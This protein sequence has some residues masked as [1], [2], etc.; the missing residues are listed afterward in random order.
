MPEKIKRKEPTTTIN[1]EKVYRPTNGKPSKAQMELINRYKEDYKIRG[2][3]D[4]TL[5]GI[6]SDC[7]YEIKECI[8]NLIR[9]KD[10][11]V[12]KVLPK[13]LD[14]KI[15]DYGM[16]AQEYFGSEVRS[17]KGSPVYIIPSS[18]CQCKKCD[19]FLPKDKFFTVKT[20]SCREASFLCKDCA[21][22]LFVEY[23]KQY[24]L[25]EALILISQKLDLIVINSVLNKY[26]DYYGTPKGKTDFTKRAFLGNYIGDI[27]I[28]LYTS[29]M[30]S[31]DCCF[32]KSNLH[33][34]PFRDIYPS[35]NQEQI[36]DDVVM[37]QEDEE[38]NPTTYKSV[39]VLK[40]KWGTFDKDDLYWLEDKYNEWYDKCEIEGLSREKLV[41][42]LCYEELDVVRTRERGGN[43]KD[44]VRSFQSLMKDADL[45]PKKKTTANI[46]SGENRF[47][48]LG[49]FIK[50][51]EKNA[52]IVVKSKEFNDVD[53]I[54]KFWKSIAGAI[55]RTLCKDNQYTQDFEKNYSKYT[56][57]VFEE[58]DQ[59][60]D[61]S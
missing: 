6:I 30:P 12:F 46:A 36:Y 17:I 5:D 44:K 16:Y 54:E 37:S 47:K 58:K 23:F 45:S 15:R 18:Y 13:D 60:E 51:A 57:D 19:S 8:D 7:I 28:Y 27:N 3:V 20:D 49:E 48:S 10:P 41:K 9:Y 55:S 56:V 53:G 33:G 61:E 25:K 22:D 14:K 42:Q 40:R 50:K 1:A 26:I 39:D 59:E 34:E 38:V 2:V 21:N 35:I 24:G 31:K 32:A 29:N 4:N 52:P 43:V 11:K